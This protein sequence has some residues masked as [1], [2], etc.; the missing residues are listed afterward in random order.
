MQEIL[1]YFLVSNN[2]DA[3]IEDIENIFQTVG[4]EFLTEQEEYTVSITDIWLQYDKQSQGDLD[5]QI[6]EQATN[7]MLNRYIEDEAKIPQEETI[8]SGAIYKTALVHKA[9]GYKDEPVVYDTTD[10]HKPLEDMRYS[11][12]SYDGKYDCRH[13]MTFA[14]HQ[15]F[16][17]IIEKSQYKPENLVFGKKRRK[18]N[19][20]TNE[21]SIIPGKH[22]YNILTNS[23]QKLFIQNP[24][25]SDTPLNMSNEKF[26]EFCDVLYYLPTDNLV[27]YSPDKQAKKY[28]EPNIF[29]GILNSSANFVYGNIKL[30]AMWIY[31]TAVNAF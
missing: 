11:W 10:T 5:V 4:Q 8:E 26:N 16:T 1:L 31:K 28:K 20:D 21:K 25:F 9:F 24:H 23:N 29:I 30:G 22:Q 19:D 6:L 14:K 15:K 3:S 27:E 7:K 12:E 13:L 17:D 2:I 18:E